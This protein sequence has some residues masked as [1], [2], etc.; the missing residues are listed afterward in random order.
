[1]VIILLWWVWH[2]NDLFYFI[3]WK[4]FSAITQSLPMITYY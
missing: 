4:V 1:M 3:T 2:L